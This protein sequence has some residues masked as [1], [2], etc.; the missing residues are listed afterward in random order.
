MGEILKSEDGENRM[1]KF[2]KVHSD[3]AEKMLKDA[4]AFLNFHHDRVAFHGN[5]YGRGMKTILVPKFSKGTLITWAKGRTGIAVTEHNTD[6]II[7]IKELFSTNIGK[8]CHLYLFGF[9]QMHTEDSWIPARVSRGHP[10]QDQQAPMDQQPAD[11]T[12]SSADP[13]PEEFNKKREGPVEI[14]VQAPERKKAKLHL[15]PPSNFSYVKGRTW[16]TVQIASQGLF[17]TK[18]RSWDHLFVFA[19]IL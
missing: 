13:S 4:K 3:M 12:M 18:R 5:R 9:V 10:A 17:C 8:L 2:P 11:E 15:N 19:F 16:A 1:I 6:S 7:H 14:V